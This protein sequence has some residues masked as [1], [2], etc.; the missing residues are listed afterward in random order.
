MGRIL[1]IDEDS[2]FLTRVHS[3]LSSGTREVFTAKTAEEGLAVARTQMLE[4]A[5]I[6]KSL[7][8]ASG[9]PV[10]LYLKQLQPDLEIIVMTANASVDSAV[11]ALQTG[12]FDYLRKPF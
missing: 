9:W 3:M 11:D 12:V 4:V 10:S 2:L 1:V 6:E 8:N 5:L 7:G